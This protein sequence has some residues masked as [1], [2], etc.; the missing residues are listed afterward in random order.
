M[1]TLRTVERIWQLERQNRN[2]EEI[3]QRGGLLY[4]KFHGFMKDMENIK[5]AL[6]KATGAYEA[7]S[8]K[9]KTGSGNLIGQAQ[10]LHDLGANAKKPKLTDSSSSEQ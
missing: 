1:A 9:L 3:A 10:K 8:A 2:A 4:D 7:A 6:G 5:T